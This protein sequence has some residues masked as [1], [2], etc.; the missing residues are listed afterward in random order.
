MED[1]IGYKQFFRCSPARR[2]PLLSAFSPSPS[3]C[4]ESAIMYVSSIPP[5]HR[6]FNSV[7]SIVGGRVAPGAN[8]ARRQATLSR[9]AD[10]SKRVAYLAAARPDARLPPQ[11][12]R[13]FH[14]IEVEGRGRFSLIA[15]SRRSRPK[16]A[17]FGRR[18]PPCRLEGSGVTIPIL[19]LYPHSRCNCRCLR[20]LLRQRSNL[21]ESHWSNQWLTNFSHAERR[22][23]S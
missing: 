17:Y 12:L 13:G 8:C 7:R 18:L 22:G 19:I 6:M 16:R 5:S 9:Q 15:M 21:F 1:S 14:R 23:G 2:P 4:C 11:Q 10:H 20:I 3:L